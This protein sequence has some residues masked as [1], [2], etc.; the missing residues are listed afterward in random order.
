MHLE[1]QLHEE[2]GDD[3]AHRARVVDHENFHDVPPR[4]WRG[5]GEGV[6]PSSELSR[7]SGAGFSGWSVPHPPDDITLE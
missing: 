2:L 6:A 5:T 7:F 1:A 3:A 4:V